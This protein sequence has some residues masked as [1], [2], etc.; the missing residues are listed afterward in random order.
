MLNNMS[1]EKF[2]TYVSALFSLK[3][4]EDEDNYCKVARESVVGIVTCYEL[5]SPET[6]SKWG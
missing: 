6:E 1:S 4:E 5:D 2:L 3:K